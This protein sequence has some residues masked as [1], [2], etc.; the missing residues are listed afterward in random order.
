MLAEALQK[1]RPRLARDTLL[2]ES[3]GIAVDQKKLRRQVGDIVFTRLGGEPSGEET[4]RRR[5]SRSARRRWTR[6]SRA[7]TRR[8]TCRPIRS[9]SRAT[10]VPV[11]AVNKPLLEAYNAMWDASLQSRAGRAGSR[12]AVHASRARGDSE[13]ARKAERLYLR[14]APPRVVI[15]IDKA[16]LKGKDKGSSSVRRVADGRPTPPPTR[17]PI[18]S[19][20]SS[21]WRRAIPRAAADSLLAA[22]H[23]RA[24][25]RAGVRRGAERRGQ[26]DARGEGRRGDR[27]AGARAARA[28]RRARRARLARPVGD[29][30]MSTEFVFATAQYESGD[31]DS[32][33]LVP[34]NI[35][36]TIARYT[37]INVAPTGVT[38]ALS[39]DAH[40]ALSAALSHRP[41]ARAIQRRRAA[42][43]AAVRRARRHAVRRRPQPRHRRHVSQDGDRG[44]RANRRP[45][46]RAAERP[47]ALFGVLQVRGSADDQPRAQRLGRQSRA[48][49]PARRHARRPHRGAVQQQGLQLGVELSSR[50]ASDFCRSTTRGSP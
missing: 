42:E 23:R 5:E 1:K 38:V 17:A 34:P 26:R 50:H 6:C 13:S 22:P 27:G 29:R 14:G 44:D 37:E 47:S 35:I 7:P 43:P 36:D 41:S 48:Q 16:R 31:W 45:A 28:R 21:S 2:R 3:H 24:R 19:R 11:V 12:A 10:R 33:P 9:T 46:R 40:A 39:D 20:A 25:R 32:A 15:D 49:A 18:D 4:H 8:R 30:S